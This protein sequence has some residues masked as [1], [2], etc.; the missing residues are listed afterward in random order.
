MSRKP[1]VKISE[2]DLR[3]QIVDAGQH[4]A[5][6]GLIVAGEGNIS[7]RVNAERI[8]ITPAG[9]RKGNVPVGKLVAIDLAGRPLDTGKGRPSSEWGMH[10]C[11]YQQRPDITA[12]VHAHPPYAVACSVAGISL[13]EPVLPEI[14]AA[15]GGIATAAY[16]TPSTPE[17]AASISPLVGLH[18]AIILKN[19]GVLTVG[20]DLDS[21]LQKMEMIEHL[22]QVVFLASQ[23]GRVDHLSVVQVEKVRRTLGHN[24]KLPDGE[25]I[26]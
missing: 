8:V 6:H 7:V 3:R 23:I 1:D 14:V 9:E 13:G 26:S 21:A 4:L 25:A 15:V 10:V 22:A 20:P 12:C 19:H 16:A 17:V 11:A 5:Y 24:D 18:D 2:A